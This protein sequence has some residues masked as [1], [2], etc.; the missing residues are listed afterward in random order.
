MVAENWSPDVSSGKKDNS[1]KRNSGGLDVDLD[2]PAFLMGSFNNYY[3][4]AVNWINTM[5]NPELIM[6]IENMLDEERRTQA[7]NNLL[8]RAKKS[9]RAVKGVVVKIIKSKKFPQEI[10]LDMIKKVNELS[11]DIYYAT[12]FPS[13]SSFIKTADAAIAR[14]V[15]REDYRAAGQIQKSI[16]AKLLEYQPKYKVSEGGN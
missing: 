4:D 15:A 16:A 7:Y 11:T 13:C 12:E 10:C 2:D 1:N 14:A 3:P 8:E 6:N 5:E 9:F